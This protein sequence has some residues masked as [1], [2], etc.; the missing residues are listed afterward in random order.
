MNGRCETDPFDQAR[1]VCGLCYGEFCLGCLMDVKGR[2]Y[3][4]C[5]GCAIIASGVRAGAKP[6]LRG[7]K[8]TAAARRTA[9]QEAPIQVSFQ[10]FDAAPPETPATAF[11]DTDDAEGAEETAPTAKRKRRGKAAGGKTVTKAKRDEQKPK[12]KGKSKAGTK[13]SA[14][15]A[16]TTAPIKA[17]A[18]KA[19]KT[20]PAAAS[21]ASDDLDSTAGDDRA[22][23]AS[24][25][26]QLDS[27]RELGTNDDEADSGSKAHAFRKPRPFIKSKAERTAAESEQN[28]APTA[29]ADAKLVASKV[30]NAPAATAGAATSKSSPSAKPAE[31]VGAQD[32]PKPMAKRKSKT[33][34]RQAEQRK[35]AEQKAAQEHAE[36]QAA[37]QKAQQKAS[38]KTEPA[39]KQAKPKS[40]PA[41]TSELSSPFSVAPP[42]ALPRRRASPDA[43]QDPYE[44]S[45]PD[46]VETTT[47]DQQLSRRRSDSKAAPQPQRNPA[48][49]LRQADAA[50]GAEQAPPPERRSSDD[51]STT[52]S[53]TTG[54]TGYDEPAPMRPPAWTQRPRSRKDDTKESAEVAQPKA[55][56][57]PEAKASTGRAPSGGAS[58]D[59]A[60]A[61]T[62]PL[63]RRRRSSER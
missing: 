30:V 2:K 60:P 20:A 31:P 16:A 23:A 62:K 4:L 40:D 25:V 35:V 3:P 32:R 6:A 48:G 11:P 33:G 63:P 34:A 18:D 61:G 27:I 43:G 56:A 45:N 12:K 47:P 13:K 59:E 41:V 29:P 1:N 50:A 21:T 36:Q 7:P 38:A 42:P 26:D 57:K 52:T 44:R 22:G 39:Q 53:T 9:L 37:Q 10:F 49:G 46:R 28:A 14:D 24:A 58:A 19:G 8:R 5:R 54:T 15:E 55:E 17:T 51:S